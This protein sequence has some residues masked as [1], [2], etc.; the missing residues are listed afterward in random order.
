MHLLPA[1]STCLVSPALGAG[2]VRC[3]LRFIFQQGGRHARVHAANEDLG[4]GVYI[5]FL[6]GVS[7]WSICVCVRCHGGRLAG[8]DKRR[9]HAGRGKRCASGPSGHFWPPKQ[10]LRAAGTLFCVELTGY[11]SN[12][13]A[14]HSYSPLHPSL[15]PQPRSRERLRRNRYRTRFLNLY[16]TGRS[17]SVETTSI[18]R[19]LTCTTRCAWKAF[20]SP[21]AQ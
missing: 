15:P 9:C 10:R 7:F 8:P 2:D 18:R 21:S 11:Y 14:D 13:S 19:Y 12:H 1:P 4:Y 5:V 20:S 17:V 3:Q 16:K 6:L